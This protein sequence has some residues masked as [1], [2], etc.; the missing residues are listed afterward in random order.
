MIRFA[1]RQLAAAMTLTA[2]SLLTPTLAGEAVPAAPQQQQQQAI[3][4]PPPKD[5]VVPAKTKDYIKKAVENPDRLPQH[6][7]HDA[8]RKPAEV[9]QLANVRPG[10]RVVEF[11]SYGNYWSTMLSDIIG[12]KGELYMYD[13]PAFEPYAKYGQ[14]FVEKHK[15]TKFQNINHDQIE[16]PKQVDLIVCVACFH[17]LL[18]TTQMAAIHTKMFKALK[19]GGTFIVVF[20]TARDSTGTDDTGK[21][22]RIDKEVVRGYVQAAGFALTEES[23]ILWNSED[24]RTGQVLTETEFDLADKGFY[25]FRK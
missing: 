20:A 6:K 7:I 1:Q 2:L 19:P 8:Y 10:H 15:N 13:L 5:Y 12:E 23:R 25:I 9:L 16:L 17:E 24:K 11:S 14:A 22:H 18:L 3:D 4:A 21:L